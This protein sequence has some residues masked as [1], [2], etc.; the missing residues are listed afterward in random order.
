MGWIE[1][2]QK[3]QRI[4]HLSAEIQLKPIAG[5]VLNYFSACS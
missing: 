4:A 5:V 3:H 2:K 1:S